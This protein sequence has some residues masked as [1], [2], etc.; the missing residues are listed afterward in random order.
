MKQVLRIHFFLAVSVWFFFSWSPKAFGADQ[1]YKYIDKEGTVHYTD[2]YEGIPPEYQSQVEVI[3][4][5][6]YPPGQSPSVS[7][8]AT[9]RLSDEQ[10]RRG[11]ERISAPQKEAQEKAAKEEEEKKLQA[12]L[13]KEKQIEELEKA[14]NA[15]VE[16][17]RRL[18]TNWMVWDR[19]TIYRLNQEIEGLKQQIQSIKE[20][21][22]K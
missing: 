4:P 2:R 16:E 5:I 11:E 15:R 18:R 7:E 1:Y 13:E 8:P 20:E 3:R 14:I 17:Q 12:R 22:G 10:T 21:L 9:P 19:N 6:A